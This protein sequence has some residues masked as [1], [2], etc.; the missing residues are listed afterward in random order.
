MQADKT[1]VLKYLLKT[2]VFFLKNKITGGV[3]KSPFF[4]DTA[5]SRRYRH[6]LFLYRHIFQLIK[7]SPTAAGN[8]S[9]LIYELSNHLNTAYNSFALVC[10]LQTGA[11]CIF[12]RFFQKNFAFIRRLKKSPVLSRE[13]GRYRHLSTRK[14]VRTWNLIAWNFKSNEV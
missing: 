3:L 1:A 7:K 2:A 8:T 14:E 5:V 6:V 4:E 12:G 9:T 10:I 11:F 13:K